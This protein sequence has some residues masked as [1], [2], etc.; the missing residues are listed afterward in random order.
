MDLLANRD[1]VCRSMLKSARQG[2]N[3]DLFRDVDGM[4]LTSRGSEMMTILASAICSSHCVLQ[5]QIEGYFGIG[6]DRKY[7]CLFGLV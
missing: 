1:Y 3:L 6:L 4:E 5:E 7:A 2:Q